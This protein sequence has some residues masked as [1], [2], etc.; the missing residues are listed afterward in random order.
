MWAG[1]V[2][3]LDF[4]KPFCFAKKP[5]LSLSVARSKTNVGSLFNLSPAR[6]F[7]LISW[8]TTLTHLRKLTSIWWDRIGS[9]QP[10]NGYRSPLVNIS[11]KFFVGYLHQTSLAQGISWEGKTRS[12]SHLIVFFVMIHVRKWS[13]TC[14]DIVSLL[15]LAR[16]LLGSRCQIW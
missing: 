16:T 11:I 7:G 10:S 14:S 15:D 1:R 5:S 12:F 8:T 9:I 3:R 2:P 4:P 13:S 6:I